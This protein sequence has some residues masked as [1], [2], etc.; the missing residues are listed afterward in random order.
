MTVLI[1]GGAGYFGSLLSTYLV[2]SGIQVVVYDKLLY[3]GE[4]LLSVIGSANFQLIIDDIR[5]RAA[6]SSAIKKADAVVHL[7]ALV[8]EEACLVDPAATIAINV[9]ATKQL[10]KMAR[11]SGVKR[12]IFSSTCSNYGRVDTNSIADEDWPLRPLSL[13]AQ[14]KI[15]AEGIILRASSKNFS[16]CVL[17]F[18]TICGLSPRM[19]FDLLVNDMARSAALGKT[20]TIFA[21]NAWR[22]FL[23]IRDAAE[24]IYRCLTTQ[25]QNIAGQIFNVVGENYQKK[26]LAQLVIKHFP[27]VPIDIKK[28]PSATRDYRVSAERIAKKIHF[29]PNHSIKEAFIEVADAVKNGIFPDPFRTIYDTLPDKKQLS[30]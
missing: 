3:G 10:V 29:H 12:L 22:P 1:T 24:I 27:A 14:T 20:I 2:K 8:G 25:T 28:R 15:D 11:T 23:H 18:G 21:P 19:R 7:A 13:Y 26:Q 30:D 17:R 9:Q 6:L 5:N 4:G 16:T